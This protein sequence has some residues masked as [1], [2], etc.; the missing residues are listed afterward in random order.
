[1]VCSVDIEEVKA[2]IEWQHHDTTR[3][4]TEADPPSSSIRFTLRLD[5]SFALFEIVIPIK[6]KDYP[7]SSAIYVHINPESITSLSHSIKDN[8]PDASDLVFPS[9]T[10][11]NLDLDNTVSILIPTFIKEP[12]VAARPRSGKI[13]DS[14]YELLH[15]TSLRIYIPDDTLSLEQ[16]DSISTAVTQQQLK[17]FSGPD[18]DVS[19]L[20]TGSGAKVTTLPRAPPPSY[21]KAAAQTNIPSYNESTTFDPPTHKRKRK[22][23]ASEKDGPIWAKLLELETIIQH[24]APQDALVQEAQRAEILELRDKL[25]RCEK[26]VLDLEAEV[27]GLR[28]AQDDANDAESVELTELRDDVQTLEEKIDFV[29]RGKDD[30]EFKERLK[31]ELLGELILRISRG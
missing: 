11:L 1:M 17:P 9:A 6:Y 13:L 31:E 7:T 29:A 21:N 19:R 10:S 26:R 22:Q 5:A 28:Q 15:T 2:V 20:F 25:A 24:R 12:V 14:L 27:A 8:A 4:L 30:E 16:L 3:W 18:F 23:E